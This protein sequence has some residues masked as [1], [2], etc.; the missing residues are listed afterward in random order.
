MI[1]YLDGLYAGFCRVVA[2]RTHSKIDKKGKRGLISCTKHL[3][4][5]HM[6]RKKQRA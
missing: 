1:Y 3:E 2:F 6:L 4:H 5:C